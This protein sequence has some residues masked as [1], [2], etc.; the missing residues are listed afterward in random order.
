MN[1]SDVFNNDQ[2]DLKNKSIDYFDL[3]KIGLLV[4]CKNLKFRFSSKPSDPNNYLLSDRKI[5][6]EISGYSNEVDNEPILKDSV[7]LKQPNA[8]IFFKNKKIYVYFRESERRVEK[9]TNHSRH[10]LCPRYSKYKEEQISFSWFIEDRSLFTR[11]C[12]LNSS[13]SKLNLTLTLGKNDLYFKELIQNNE[14][15][16]SSPIMVQSVDFYFD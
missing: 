11:L 7:F 15:E 8:N 13:S 14:N 5:E 9:S 10:F 12:V 3:V 4:N 1:N 2:N 6:Q 16:L